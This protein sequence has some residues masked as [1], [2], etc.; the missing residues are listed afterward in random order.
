MKRIKKFLVVALLLGN[1]VYSINAKENGTLNTDSEDGFQ[2]VEIVM[3]DTY[4]PIDPQ[5]SKLMQNVAM[6][7]NANSK[8]INEKVRA[9][10]PYW[11]VING[12]KS[13]YD[14]EGNLMYRKGTKMVIDVSEHNGR[15]DWNKVKAAGVDG[16]IIR[17]GWGY[18]GEDKYFQ[19]NVSECNRLNIP[20]GIYLYSYAYDAN[21]AY[22]EANG[23][24]EMLSK[25][26]LN[27]SYPIYYDIEN[28]T[29]WNDNGI[30]R[31]PPA[32]PAAYEKVI[33]TYINRMNELGYK[34][35]VHVY[36]YRYYLQT[37]LKSAKILPYVSWIAAYTQTLGYENKYYSGEQGWQYTSS[38]SVSGIDGRVD[39]NCF[40]DEILNPAPRMVEL[41]FEQKKISKNETYTFKASVNPLNA[42]QKVTW[43]TG[44]SKV[45]TVDANGTVTGKSSGKTWL[46]AKTINGL[47]A[48]CLIEVLPE[49]THVEIQSNV[50]DLYTGK[51]YKFNAYVYPSSAT[52]KVTWRTGN[53]KVATVDASGRVTTKSV[54]NTWLYAITPNG[55]ETR[56]LLRVKEELPVDIKLNYTEKDITLGDSEVIKATV[57]PSNASQKVTWRTGNSNVAIVDA[58]GK[59]TTKSVG[60]TWLY[61]KTMNGLEAKCMIRVRPRAAEIKLDETAKDITV[62]DSAV[63]KVRITP[64][65]AIQKATWRTGNSNVATVDVNGKVT[66]KSVGN[67]WLYAKTM[68][69]LEAK[70]MIRVRPKAAEIKLDETAKDITVGDS[71]V[72]KV[73]ITPTN[74]IQKATWRTGNSNVATVDANGKVTAK[75]VGN[76]W[77]YAKTD[78][79]LEAKCMIRVRPKAIEIELDK[80]TKDITVGDSAV[81]KAHITPTNAI[82]KVTWRTGNPNKATVDANGKVTAKSVGNTWLYAK[83]DNGLEAKCMIRVHP[84][85]IEIK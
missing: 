46:Y 83:T 70:C 4:Q 53:S 23:T 41:N 38:G 24:A 29:P 77:L 79:G 75:S 62:G 32:D 7:N 67:T 10:N 50:K 43:R 61:A 58:N 6:G 72:I 49:P 5:V 55:K 35:I 11:S 84:K 45:A 26:S 65:N 37:K 47:E 48:K 13:F 21:F 15:I 71:A 31:R 34:K 60:N 59:V 51:Q 66:T 78:N 12:V 76:T 14:A 18:L 27:L 3:E 16:A 9:S 39:M 2:N 33:G 54:G 36:S 73:R 74:A 64:T 28:F 80:A 52:Q 20:Y 40:S 57:A 81:I 25:V 1:V 63:I 85:A 68:N 22:A 30:T 44:N 42:S 82:Q 56:S 69:G 19:R 17:V 8:D